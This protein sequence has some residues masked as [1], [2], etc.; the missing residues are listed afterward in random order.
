MERRPRAV[1]MRDVPISCD[2]SL[3]V[4]L[5]VESSRERLFLSDPEGRKRPLHKKCDYLITMLG[6]VLVEAENA[7]YAD[8]C[9][10][11]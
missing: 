7:P 4:K 6:V 10:L 9:M 8:C 3:T 1:L 2:N 11:D 5:E